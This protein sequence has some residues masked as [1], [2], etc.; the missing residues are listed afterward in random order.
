MILEYFEQTEKSK[1]GKPKPEAL[2]VVSMAELQQTELPPLRFVVEGLL[3][4]GLCI[5]ASP[6]KYGKSWLVLDL[7][8]RVAAGEPLLGRQTNRGACLYLALEDSHHRLQE[9][10]AKLLAGK[11]APEGFDCAISCADIAEGLTR[12][13]GGIRR[14]APADRADRHRHVPENT[15]WLR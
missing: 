8:L 2:A 6:P 4:R 13:A 15:Q 14:R 1:S 12:A 7:C 9:R 10:A 5:L 3:P 11:A